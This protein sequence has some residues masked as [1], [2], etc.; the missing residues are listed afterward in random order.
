LH[1]GAKEFNPSKHQLR[2]FDNN[3]RVWKLDAKITKPDVVKFLP[4]LSYADKLLEKVYPEIHKTCKKI[5]TKYRLAETSKNQFAVNT[6]E[7]AMHRDFS[8][9]LDVL[10]YAGNWYGG[11][12]EIPQLNLRINL[13][14]GDV[15]IMDSVLFHQVERV[16]GTRFS[17][18]FFTKNHNEMGII[19]II[20]TAS[21]TAS[22]VG[23]LYLLKNN[24]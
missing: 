6:R 8:V 22:C 7:S 20:I 16:V 11:S 9:G 14:A 4:E 15:V 1:F 10:M 24:K 2:F 23:Q 19:I 3:P 5:P 21:Y 13:Q 18:V 17:I 12:L